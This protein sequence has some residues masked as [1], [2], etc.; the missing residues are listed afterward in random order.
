[1]LM[2]QSELG[3]GRMNH[4]HKRPLLGVYRAAMLTNLLNPKVAMFFLAFLPQFIE[5]AHGSNAVPFVILGLT[6]TLTG[7]VWCVVLALASARIFSS[8]RRNPAISTYVRR[9][10]GSVLIYLGVRLAVDEAG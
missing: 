5:P 1:M 9:V 4:H 7:T 2:E 6:F 10:S 8:L 3:P